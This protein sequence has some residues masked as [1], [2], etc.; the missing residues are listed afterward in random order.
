MADLVE[1]VLAEAAKKE[2]NYKTTEV[3][4]DVELDIDAGNLLAVDTNPIDLKTFRLNT[5]YWGF[6]F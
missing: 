4:K 6:I 5:L 3:E 2:A 1:N